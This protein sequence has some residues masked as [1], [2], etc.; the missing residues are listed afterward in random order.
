MAHALNYVVFL[1][2]KVL[3]YEHITAT[4]DT[5]VSH[6]PFP[7]PYWMALFDGL[8]FFVH[9]TYVHWLHADL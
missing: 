1:I 4:A 6:T 5:D 8:I 7:S 3:L 2:N 9:M